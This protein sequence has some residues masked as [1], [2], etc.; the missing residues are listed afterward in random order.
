MPK[1][2]RQTDVAKLAG[3]SPATVSIILNNRLDSNVR[4][5]ADTRARVLAAVEQLGYVT[6]PV[7]RS[8]AGGQTFLLG[9]F[10][11]ESIFARPVRDAYAPF[12][13]G[14]EQEA[15]QLGYD[16]LLF[17]GTGSNRGTAGERQIYR[18]NINRLRMADGAILLGADARQDELQ[19]L[20]AEPYPFVSIGRRELSSGEFSYVAADY[21]TATARI[22]TE[23]LTH[24]HRQIVYLGA[25]LEDESRRDCYAGYLTAYRQL[26]L[27]SLA[28]P[29]Q[30]LL[31]AQL[32]PHFLAETLASGSSAFVVEPEE[33]LVTSFFQSMALLGKK[34]P[35]DFSVALL[36][37]PPAG[38]VTPN[39]VTSFSIP[40]EIMGR[41]SVKLLMELLRA[42]ATPKARQE[43]VACTH[44]AGLT[45][46]PP[47]IVF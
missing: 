8:L 2:P 21:I 32:T 12:L 41:R 31:A 3:V 10:A 33:T 39:P 37:E 15:E 5:S 13:F 28:A 43:I 7:A 35:S 45:I 30:R 44:V 4:V 42:P 47:A 40:R 25:A 19:R 20:I 27:A 6:D 34:A 17:T 14:I 46:A 11:F 26:G 38:V 29:A 18:G 23:M 16:L 9:L 24:G 1:R 22:V 36:G